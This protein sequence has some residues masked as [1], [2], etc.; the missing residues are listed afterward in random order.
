M[1]DQHVIKAIRA[2]HLKANIGSIEADPRWRLRWDKAWVDPGGTIFGEGPYV[3]V[4]VD[5]GHCA[6]HDHTIRVY[7]PERLRRQIAKKW[8]G[9]K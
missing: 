7:A 2:K 9:F 5:C 3:K 1:T 8:T 6:Q 4:P